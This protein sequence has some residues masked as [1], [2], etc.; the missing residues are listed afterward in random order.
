MSGHTSS[1]APSVHAPAITGLRTSPF[2][3]VAGV[4]RT[5]ARLE[6]L[7]DDVDVERQLP[8][9]LGDGQGR[10][11]PDARAARV[12]TPLRPAAAPN[13]IRPRTRRASLALDP[14]EAGSPPSKYPAR[15]QPRAR[16]H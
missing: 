7:D 15:G 2:G 14:G 8:G 16:A 4:A 11:Y 3:A 10:R 12:I 5:G 6:A 9:S 1:P 13:R